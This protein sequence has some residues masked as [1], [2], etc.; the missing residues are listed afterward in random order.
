MAK[1]FVII[2]HKKLKSIGHVES[3]IAHNDRTSKPPNADPS[4]TWMNKVFGEGVPQFTRTLAKVTRK[5]TA[6]DPVLALEYIVTASPESM[7]APGF[8]QAGYFRAAREYL[9]EL[10]GAENF[11]HGAIHMDESNPHMHLVYVPLVQTPASTRKRSVVVGKAPDG[12]QLRE[13]REFKVEPATVLNGK[14][15]TGLEASQR[16]QTEFAERVGVPFGLIRGVRK[17]GAHH[18]EIKEFYGRLEAV[19]TELAETRVQLE[20]AKAELSDMAQQR[21][22]L[23]RELRELPKLVFERVG[24]VMAAIKGILDAGEWN[25]EADLIRGPLARLFSM[26]ETQVEPGRGMLLDGIRTQMQRAQDEA[27]D[28]G[29]PVPN[30]GGE[31]ELAEVATRKLKP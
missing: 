17:S 31:A 10:L 26:K 25:Y 16:L 11:V 8:D 7:Q 9:D 2:R 24:A 20:V 5:S 19:K 13:V 4:K 30:F 14:H 3:A 22:R 12:S 23:R 29:G 27:R 21:D 15:F 6:R 28:R 18:T 1:K